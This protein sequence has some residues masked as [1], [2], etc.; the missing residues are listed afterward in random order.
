MPKKPLVDCALIS[1]AMFLPP[2]SPRMIP[3]P[4]NNIVSVAM[5]AGTSKIVTMKPLM[6]PMARPS[7]RHQKTATQTPISK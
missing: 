6:R 7:A 4:M 5:K 3:R 2:V 1:K